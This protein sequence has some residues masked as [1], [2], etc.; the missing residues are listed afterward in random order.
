MLGC[1]GQKMTTLL[2]VVDNLSSFDKPCVHR[3]HD[4]ELAGLD[5][6]GRWPTRI[7]QA[8]PTPMCELLARCHARRM[9]SR[10]PIGGS[11]TISESALRNA[12]DQQDRDRSELR[13]QHNEELPPGFLAAS[14]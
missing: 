8:Y 10:G 2:G 1:P 6:N 3:H 12:R 9:L 14:G 13:I 5:E 7:A 11:T 4:E